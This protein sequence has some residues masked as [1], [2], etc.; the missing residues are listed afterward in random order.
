MTDA[1]LIGQIASL[2]LGAVIAV[3]VLMWKRGDD[4][5]HDRYIMDMN[6]RLVSL[7]ENNTQALTNL[8]RAIEKIDDRLVILERLRRD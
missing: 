2:G 4:L 3:I 8:L 6:T 5:R 1:T 7:V